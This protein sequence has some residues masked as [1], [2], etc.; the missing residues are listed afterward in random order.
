MNKRLYQI[1]LIFE[2]NHNYRLWYGEDPNFLNFKKE[3]CKYL[4]EDSNKNYYKRIKSFKK[5]KL[6]EPSTWIKGAKVSAIHQ[7]SQ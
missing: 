6:S 3:T 1:V 2:I 4:E 5:R 7:K